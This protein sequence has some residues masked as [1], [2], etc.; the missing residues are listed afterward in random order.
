MSDTA[1]PAG[2]SGRD[3]A[4]QALAAYK[5]KA[6]NSPAVPPPRRQN[7]RTD[8]TG[9]RDPIPLESVLGQ[10]SSEQD[11]ASGLSGGSI[12]D[13]W[14]SLC[15]QYE[16]RVDAVAYDP[17]CGRLDLRP[18]S[19][20]YA[21]QLRLLGGQLGRQINDKIGRVVVKRIRV[22]PTEPCARQRADTGN[23]PAADVVPPLVSARREP[24]PGY[25]Q[26][27]ALVRQHKPDPHQFA[28]PYLQA[29]IAASDRFLADPRN[30]EPEHLHAEAVVEAE[31]LA[32]QHAVD[33]LGASVR[34]A[35]ATARRQ[36]EGGQ[37]MQVF[38]SSDTEKRRPIRGRDWEP[39]ATSG[40]A[41]GDRE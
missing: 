39:S 23:S 12:L 34:A 2:A 7:Q 26:A 35:R 6:G 32:A 33:P 38:A 17:K 13:Q 21:A 14:N 37:P 31:R 10:I 29:A 40:A 4:R 9:G 19:D 22:L 1:P 28:N 5:A 8:R 36:R 3:L 41:L 24:P 30:R 20:A 15:P 11:W 27:I 18:G 16:G 25:R